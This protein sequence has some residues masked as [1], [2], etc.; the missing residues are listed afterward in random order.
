MADG[1]AT[2]VSWLCL[3]PGNEVSGGKLLSARTRRTSNRAT[4]LLRLAALTVAKT[5]SAL[6]AF[7][8]RLGLRIGKAKAITATARKLAMLFHN[9]LRHQDDLQKQGARVGRRRIEPMSLIEA[10]RR[11]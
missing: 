11:L 5:D 2:S 9:T 6:G 10:P 4:S 3:S 1:Q 8:R 7:H